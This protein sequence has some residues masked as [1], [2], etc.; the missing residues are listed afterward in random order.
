LQRIEQTLVDLSA[1][2]ADLASMVEQQ[3]E[4]VAVAENNAQDTVVN[5]EK[6]NEQVE[7]GIKHA[8]NTR[9]LKW[10]CLGITVLI[11]IIVVVA[12]VAWY[13]TVGPGANKNK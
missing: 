3:D 2:Y 8:R 9:K 5:M 11:I 10:W 13:F 12:V 4:V 7:V 6:G 1:L